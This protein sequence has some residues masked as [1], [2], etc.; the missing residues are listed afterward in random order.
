MPPCLHIGRRKLVLLF[1]LEEEVGLEDMKTF[2]Q[3]SQR[4]QKWIRLLLGQVIK[5]WLFTNVKESQYFSVL[6]DEVTVLL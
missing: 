1:D 6:V 4:S 2:T 5:H 3:K